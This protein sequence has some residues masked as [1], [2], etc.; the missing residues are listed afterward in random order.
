MSKSAIAPPHIFGG[1]AARPSRGS[2]ANSARLSR[3]TCAD[4]RLPASRALRPRLHFGNH[5]L[6]EG[7]NSVSRPVWVHLLHNLDGPRLR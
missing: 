4:L 5:R 2:G 3:D 7:A 6:V 1:I